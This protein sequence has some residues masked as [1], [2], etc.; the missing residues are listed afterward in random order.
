M[1]KLYILFTV[2]VASF[3]NAQTNLIN[4]GSFD[5]NGSGWTTFTIKTDSGGSVST[6]GGNVTFSSAN[7]TG[8]NWDHYGIYQA[9]TLSPGTYVMDFDISFNGITNTWSE[10]LLGN[11]QPENGKDYKVGGSGTDQIAALG[12]IEEVYN[13][14]D[15]N[16]GTQN[17]P[18]ITSTGSSNNGSVEK[19][20]SYVN[21]VAHTGGSCDTSTTPGS[22]NFEITTAGTYYIVF[23]TGNWDGNFGSNG[24]I[25]D[26]VTL[27]DT[28]TLKVSDFEAEPFSV[29]PNP[30]ND[31]WKISSKSEK[32]QSIE[33]YDLLGKKVKSLEPNST[34]V[35]I[36]AS[37][38][39]PGVYTMNIASDLGV[40]RKKIVKQ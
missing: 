39:T 14:W 19:A 11:L 21:Q 37:N 40:T 8:L 4:N 26:N 3:I 29:Y 35:N 5:S 20:S 15:C 10:L 28:S 9:I 32:M 36:D 6:S 38:L 2:F 16:N 30:S 23:K 33:I 17:N 1:K 31:S 25:I 27:Y 22:L 24:V 12:F 18:D 7:P 13:T 34:S